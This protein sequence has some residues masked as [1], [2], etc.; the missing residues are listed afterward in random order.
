METFWAPVRGFR[1]VWQSLPQL[2][3][4]DQMLTACDEA[5]AVLK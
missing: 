1:D 5:L 3:E 4:I 2:A